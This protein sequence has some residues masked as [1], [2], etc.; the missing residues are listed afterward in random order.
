MPLQDEALCLRAVQQ[1]HLRCWFN[2]IICGDRIGIVENEDLPL[3]AQIR[4]DELFD[5]LLFSCWFKPKSEVKEQRIGHESRNIFC[6]FRITN[7]R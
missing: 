1:Q 4:I 6:E 7:A 2:I 3:F 5:T